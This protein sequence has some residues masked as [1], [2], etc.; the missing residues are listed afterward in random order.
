MIKIN[1]T[2]IVSDLDGT[3]LN[4]EERLTM[5]TRAVI[6]G[7]V[8]W[9]GHFTFATARPYSSAMRLLSGLITSQP[10]I[11]CNGA[12]II[13]PITDKTLTSINFSREQVQ[14]IKYLMETLNLCPLVFSYEEDEE[15]LLF[16]E[17]REN[18]GILHFLN[19]QKGQKR[20]TAVKETKDLYQGNIAD[21]TCIGTRE[22]LSYLYERMNR[23]IKYTC[24][25]QQE[26]NRPEYWCEIMP[27]SAT[28][29]ESIKLLRQLGGYEQIITFGDGLNDVSMFREADWCYAVE[30]AHPILKKM[31]TGY[32]KNCDMD[33]V[34]RWIMEHMRMY[35]LTEQM[36]NIS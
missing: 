32:I 29:G 26:L 36:T 10:V 16:V 5:Q 30:N 24:I 4:S 35:P 21:I 23:N 13:D 2:L 33:G 9:G 20:I 25:F 17:G 34:A 15:R 19:K 14:E 8:K 18:E 6:N 31:A 7:F 11:V 1:R 3:L 27:R 12:R 28:K 22:E